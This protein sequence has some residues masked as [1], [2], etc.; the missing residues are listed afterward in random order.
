[1]RNLDFVG[2]L[3]VSAVFPIIAL[4]T[5]GVLEN[6][7]TKKT[8][9]AA[10]VTQAIAQHSCTTEQWIE[11][12]QKFEVCKEVL[13]WRKDKNQCVVQAIQSSCPKGKL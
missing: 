6:A 10:E 8:Q 9:E 7:Q 1:M 5:I 13:K 2:V 11:F 3:A 4:V 12:R